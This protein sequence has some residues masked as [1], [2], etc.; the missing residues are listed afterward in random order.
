MALTDAERKLL[1]ELEKTLTQEDPKLASKFTQVPSRVHPT[2]AILAVIGVL[3]G[4]V[5][6]V[7]G[8]SSYWW[9]SVVG[10]VIMLASAVILVSAWSKPAP[11]DPRPGGPVT[12]AKGGDF[13]SRLEQ[14]W[15]DRQEQ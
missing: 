2:R 4:L 3:V 9:I 14:R 13:L 10:F 5:A 7:V 12:A 8:M 11:G 1:D 6:L 15:R